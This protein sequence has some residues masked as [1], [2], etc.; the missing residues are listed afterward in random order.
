MPPQK[1][2]QTNILVTP[3]T[4]KADKDG[5]YHLGHTTLYYLLFKY[6]FPAVILFLLELILLGIAAGGN[7]LPP[8]SEWVSANTA[9]AQIV[10]IT[11][12]GILPL[13]ILLAIAFALVMAYGWYFSFRYKLGDNDLS[14]EK[15]LL[16]RQEISIPFHQIQN[17]DVEQSI[18][19]RIFG[20]AD[21]IILTAGHEDPVHATIDESEIIM[22][23][24]SAHEA[25]RLQQYLLDR[26]NVQRIVSINPSVE[27]PVPAPLQ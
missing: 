11:A 1:Q 3:S 25:R 7:T 14:F 12:A 26:A 16:G 8:F 27:P 4:R 19:Y 24:L 22:P 5:Y 20:L 23:A 18:F 2:E 9:S 21:L 10:H 13:L 6:G 15:G 17:V